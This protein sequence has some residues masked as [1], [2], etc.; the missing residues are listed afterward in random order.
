MGCLE[1]K[2]SKYSNNEWKNFNYLTDSLYNNNEDCV[3]NAL[4]NDMPM[5]YEEIMVAIARSS[6][7]LKHDIFKKYVMLIEDKHELNYSMDTYDC[8]FKIT[9][10]KYFKVGDSVEY[11]C[12]KIG[13]ITGVR[14]GYCW[15]KK[16]NGNSSTFYMNEIK[17]YTGRLTK[18][19]LNNNYFAQLSDAHGTILCEAICE[20]NDI[21]SIIISLIDLAKPFKSNLPYIKQNLVWFSQ[22]INKKRC[23]TPT[24][25]TKLLKT[26]EC[27]ICLDAQPN[28]IYDCGHVTNCR[29]C[30]SGLNNCPICRRPI[31]SIK[32]AYL[33]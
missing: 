25:T 24:E 28:V 17:D 32:P 14:D 11:G 26:L 4:Y 9:S 33:N 31:T 8:L 1:S 18:L 10:L 3:R 12:Y 30:S 27:S 16:D 22:H 20:K 2:N 15:I 21:D 23:N 29:K 19:Y 7:Y 6:F 13:V 5:F